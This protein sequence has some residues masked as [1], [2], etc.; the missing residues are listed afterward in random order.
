MAS[1]FFQFWEILIASVHCIACIVSI[2]DK[3]YVLCI[4]SEAAA[5]PRL[6]VF[7]RDESISAHYLPQIL[8][9]RSIDFVIMKATNMSSVM[10]PEIISISV[11]KAPATPSS[12]P[13]HA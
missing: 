6:F 8:T 4:W 10:C 5:S 9:V 12:K 13:I 3:S 11:T 1:L 7:V 2:L